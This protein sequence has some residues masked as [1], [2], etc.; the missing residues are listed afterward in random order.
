MADASIDITG[1]AG[2]Q[3][4]QPQP[5][6]NAQRQTDQMAEQLK[7]LFLYFLNQSVT[8]GKACARLCC[9]AQQASA[10]STPADLVL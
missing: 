8:S 7:P 9:Y 1:G 10:L 4:V 5:P 6:G 3:K 2:R